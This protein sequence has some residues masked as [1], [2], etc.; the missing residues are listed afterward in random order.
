LTDKQLDNNRLRNLLTIAIVLSVAAIATY[1]YRYNT[2]LQLESASKR[3]MAA[4]EKNDVRAVG[5]E[6][7]KLEG[8]P[9]Y[10]AQVTLLQGFVAL[11]NGE[12]DKSLELLQVASDVPETR[13]I[14]LTL[15]G[16][17]LLK[18]QRLDDARALLLA[19][20][21]A[22]PNCVDAHRWLG[23]LYYDLG[24][25]EQAL[26][27]L[28]R[29]GQLAPGDPRPYRLIGLINKDYERYEAAIRAYQESLRRNPSMAVRHA[30]QI[31]LAQS[32]I[33]HRDYRAALQT[34]EDVPASPT[35]ETLKAE[36]L[37][38]LG[39]QD[40]ASEVLRKVL[41]Q[42]P[43]FGPALIQLG[44][45]NLESG[46]ADRAAELLRQ[47]IEQT[48]QDDIARY[49]LAQAYGQLGKEDLAKQEMDK[50]SY[51]KELR[52]RFAKLNN[53]AINRPSDAGL[54]YELGK[55]ARQLGKPELAAMWYQA[56]LNIESGNADVIKALA[57]LQTG[58]LD[59]DD[60]DLRSHPAISH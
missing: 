39:K 31:E 23:V 32:Q 42:A 27:H 41:E 43:R 3:A 13:V 28:D 19:A 7:A 36:C 56:S 17:A 16:E 60:T 11:R 10:E 4:M 26:K 33:K 29:V 51:W 1:G 57:E 48:P 22:D 44:S 37:Q 47:A 46:D 18:S 14:G 34:I 9:M 53:D 58:Q 38:S 45:L 54:R 55:L 25:M 49:K 21:D 20:V 59:S 40:Q 2:R 12:V 24:A 6:L 50:A 52:L 5:I 15:G 35:A 30:I 8:V